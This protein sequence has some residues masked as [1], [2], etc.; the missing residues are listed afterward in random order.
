MNAPQGLGLIEVGVFYHVG[1]FQR[2][3]AKGDTGDTGNAQ[4]DRL[5]RAAGGEPVIGFR[6][7]GGAGVER[8]RGAV[9]GRET[10]ASDGNAAQSRPAVALAAAVRAG[11]AVAA[12]TVGVR[13]AVP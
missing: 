13:P 2:T 7:T 4:D 12:Q 6:A 10:A 5:L 9:G 11:Q 1:G 8:E 3:A